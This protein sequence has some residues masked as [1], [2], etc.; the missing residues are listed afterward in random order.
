VKNIVN[1][2]WC[3]RIC[4][5]KR[6]N[7]PDHIL[8]LAKP[9]PT[10]CTHYVGERKKTGDQVDVILNWEKQKQRITEWRNSIYSNPERGISEK[11]IFSSIL[12]G[13]TQW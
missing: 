3:Q 5:N 11:H 12:N 4:Y 7:W 8:Q 6:K 1:T 10:W 13:V 2:V 9:K